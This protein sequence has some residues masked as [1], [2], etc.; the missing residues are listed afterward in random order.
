MKNC[1][2]SLSAEAVSCLR[3]DSR[4]GRVNIFA[5][6]RPDILL[7]S[8]STTY[9]A[10]LDGALAVSSIRGSS[11]ITVRCPMGTN[12]VVGTTSGTI[13][14]TGRAGDLR[15]TSASGSVVVDS[16]RSAD[17]RSESGKVSISR[18]EAGCRVLTASG[19]VAVGSAG[20]VEVATGSGKVDIADAAGKAR[21]RTASG[22]VD[23]S[24]TGEGDIAVETM[25]GGVTVRLPAGLRP[26]ANLYGA[27]GRTSCELG[28]G[29]DCKVAVRSMNGKIEVVSA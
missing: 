25:S 1:D 9:E 11:T 8:E 21:V 12:L 28:E 14:V 4:S 27:S 17:L 15:A 16:A 2:V 23:L 29:S 7:A 24:A 5:E 13:T 19:S 18:C 6:A 26:T 20:S 3:I 10:T 22:R